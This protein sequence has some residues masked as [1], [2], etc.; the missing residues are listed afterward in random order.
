MKELNWTYI[1]IGAGFTFLAQFGAWVQHNMQF[2]YPELDYKWWG[3]YALGIPLTFL[4]LLATKYNVEGYG[5]SIW[6]GRFVGFAIGIAIYAVCTWIV[7]KEPISTKILVQLILCTAI[8]AV[9][10]F[11]KS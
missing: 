2:K 11:W 7:F 4:F 3:W 5:G 6:A 8:L 9:Q 10:A 1:I